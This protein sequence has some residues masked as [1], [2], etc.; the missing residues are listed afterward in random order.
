[1]YYHPLILPTAATER[2]LK[3]C[4]ALSD[5]WFDSV[6]RHRAV[7]S[8]AART[9]CSAQVEN[10]G[11]LAQAEDGTQFAIRLFAYIAV[12][13][14]R[15][16]ALVAELGEIAIDAH[17]QALM[18]LD[19]DSEASAITQDVQDDGRESRTR[20]SSRPLQMMA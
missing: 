3:T 15:L 8:D 12:E 10:A 2:A 7:Q 13:P 5:V 6:E 16:A 20:A 18:V 19:S 9:F 4:R 14:F 11:K 1:M 17:R